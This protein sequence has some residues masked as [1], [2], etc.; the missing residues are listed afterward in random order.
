[1]T[2]LVLKNRLPKIIG[3]DTIKLIAKALTNRQTSIVIDGELVNLQDAQTF[4]TFEGLEF[5]Y[6]NFFGLRQ[7]PHQ[8][9]VDKFKSCK[10]P[11]ELSSPLEMLN[12]SPEKIRVLKFGKEQ[13]QIE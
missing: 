2:Y 13:K 6:G 1:M 3:K 12:I 4:N 10:C 11:G 5:Y 7:C 8:K 9:W